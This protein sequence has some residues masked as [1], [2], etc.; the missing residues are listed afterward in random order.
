[1]ANVKKSVAERTHHKRQYDRRM[2]ERQI[3]SRE[4]K[5]VSSKALDANIRPVNDQVPSAEIVIGQMFSLNK[6]SAMHEK[7]HT[8]RSCLRWKPTG[9]IFKTVGLRWIPTRN[10]FTDSTTNVDSEPLN[11]SNDDIANPYECDQTL[12]FSACTFNSSAGLV[13]HQMTLDHSSSRLGPHCLMTFDQIGSSL[14]LQSLM[15][16]DH[17]SSSLIPQCQMAS[18]GISSGPVS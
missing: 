10:V 13:L 11:G 16:F 15:S 8:P 17:I 12:Y 9:G 2:K 7:P 18:D 14:V 4:S 5:V 1:M 6:S 3:Q